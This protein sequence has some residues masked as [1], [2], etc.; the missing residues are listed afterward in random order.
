MLTTRR[1]QEP[2][3]GYS[4][5]SKTW[6]AQYAALPT[7]ANLVH[8]ADHGEPRRH[9]LPIQGKEF[10]QIFVGLFHGL[11][12]RR[13]VTTPAGQPLI[14]TVRTPPRLAL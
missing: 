1:S 6:I 2:K 10:E 4:A 3:P 13:S 14:L 8:V 9:V 7:L 11:S 5:A 12:A